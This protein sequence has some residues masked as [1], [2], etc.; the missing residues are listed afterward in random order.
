MW[1]AIARA[2]RSQVLQRCNTSKHVASNTNIFF[3]KAN[4]LILSRNFFLISRF[5]QGRRQKNFQV[6]AN[7]NRASISY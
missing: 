7:K 2:A 3:E 1:S 6:G 5:K 4:F